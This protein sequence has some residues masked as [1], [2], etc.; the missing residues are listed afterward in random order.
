MY[1]EY[2]MF[3]YLDINIHKYIYI[4]VCVKKYIY[5]YIISFTFLE[6]IFPMKKDIVKEANSIGRCL[7][8]FRGPRH[9]SHTN[10]YGSYLSQTLESHRFILGNH[11]KFWH[12]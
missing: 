2:N 5:I 8:P 12:F 10:L 4:Y 3:H 9:L 1:I 6:D 7:W 11:L